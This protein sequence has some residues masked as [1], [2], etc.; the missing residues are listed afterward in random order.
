MSWKRR[1]RG[2]TRRARRRRGHWERLF[3]LAKPD[4]MERMVVELGRWLQ[5][6]IE[7]WFRI[8]LAGKITEEVKKRLEELGHNP[9]LDG[10][11]W[12]CD[13]GHRV[14]GYAWCHLCRFQV[15]PGK[16]S[17]GGDAARS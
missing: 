4:T 15:S 16:P 8:A 5:V 9:R 7:P 10:P 14:Q 11:R 6:P 1:Q 17:A 13:A 3:R 12:R 2:S